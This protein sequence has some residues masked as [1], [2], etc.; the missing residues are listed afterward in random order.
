LIDASL[1]L[2]E[3]DA[4]GATRYRMLETIREFA[5][6][7]LAASGEADAAKNAHARYFNRFAETFE[8]ADLMPSAARAIERIEI[9]RANLQ[10]ALTWLAQADDTEH[11]LRLIAAHGNYWA[12]TANYHEARFWYERALAGG[13]GHPSNH[14]AKIQVLLA[15]TELLQGGISTSEA[16]F[17][18]GLAACRAHDEPYYAAYALLGAATAAILQDDPER[19][20]RLLNQCRLVADRIPDQRLAELV[21]GMV[22]LNLGVVSRA[23]GNL[24]LAAVQIT[25]ML[26]RSRAEDYQLG[27]LIA[28]GDL[29]DLAR[30]RA[31]WNR[32]LAF[33]RE[34]LLLGR[35]HPVKRVLIEVIESVAIVAARTGQFDRSATLLG[36]AEGLRERT[37]LRYRQPENSSSLALAIETSRLALGNDA[38]TTNREQGRNLPAGC[39]IDA[40]LDVQDHIPIMPP[41]LLTPRETE[42][43]RLL[44]QGMTD[45]D[46]AVILFISVR[47]VENHVAHILGKLDVHTRTA[48]AAAIAAGIVSHS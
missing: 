7:Q 30:D 39:I 5:N 34:A 21:R 13:E 40:A 22:S 42:I 48:A 1:V 14:R 24:D 47:T 12:A 11:F 20:A 37:G 31:E 28:L 9:E 6:E 25:D 17:A 16:L 41:A 27:M 43:A 18:E 10:V 26:Q 33:Y 32:A 4:T 46:I 19:G 3:S 36:A 29:G 35:A 8:F 45:P 38:F 2:R 15:M 23:S 44:A